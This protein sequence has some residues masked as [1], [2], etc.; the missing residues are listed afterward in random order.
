MT[1]LTYKRA[2]ELLNEIVAEKGEDYVYTTDPKAV[3]K[4]DVERGSNPH[5]SNKCFYEHVDKTPGCIIGH[6]IHKVY[7]DFDLATVENISAGDALRAA[8]AT[9]SQQTDIFLA[10]AQTTQ[11]LGKTW[12]FALSEARESAESWEH[13]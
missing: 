10:Q 2:T 1:D 5:S 6:L 7:P 4:A 11:D 13:N 3:E 9:L 12:G 8:G